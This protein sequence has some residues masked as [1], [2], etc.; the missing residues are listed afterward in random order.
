MACCRY[1]LYGAY[2]RPIKA[3]VELWIGPLRSVHELVTESASGALAVTT[4]FQFAGTAALYVY[5]HV[6]TMLAGPFW[7]YHCI[8]VRL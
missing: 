2:D 5:L 7:I 3:K 1:V 4:C 8:L 6:S